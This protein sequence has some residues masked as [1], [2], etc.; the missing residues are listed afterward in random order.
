MKF[1]QLIENCLTNYIEL[2]LS[3]NVKRNQIAST[4]CKNTILHFVAHVLKMVSRHLRAQST[5]RMC[6]KTLKGSG[7]LK[8]LRGQKAIFNK[9][10]SMQRQGPMINFVVVGWAGVPLPPPSPQPP[11]CSISWFM[12]TPTLCDAYCHF[13]GALINTE[14]QLFEA[15]KHVAIHCFCKILKLQN[16]TILISPNPLDFCSLES[17]EPV[18]TNADR[19][20]RSSLFR[21]CVPLLIRK[22]E[23]IIRQS[24]G[25]PTGAWFT[26]RMRMCFEHG[27]AYWP[28]WAHAQQKCKIVFL[29]TVL[30][31]WFLL[32]LVDKTSSI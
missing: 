26:Q 11:P 16:F 23:N 10:L 2:V 22:H 5:I 9:L 15:A 25:W 29:Q 30:A 6:R 31:I 18:K 28:F 4:I 12:L 32:T 8:R 3:T 14:T 7:T 1:W 27:G 17:G 24:R 21:G 19:N 13:I 20:K